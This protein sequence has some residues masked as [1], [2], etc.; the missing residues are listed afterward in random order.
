ML[1]KAFYVGLSSPLRHEFGRTGL[2][3]ELPP[4]ANSPPIYPLAEALGPYGDSW[5]RYVAVFRF[6]S[7]VF[8]NIAAE[9]ANGILENIKRHGASGSFPAGQERSEDFGVDIVRD[10]EEM[11][12]ANGDYATVKELEMNSVAVIS[13]ILAQSVALDSYGDTVDSLMAT[14]ASINSTV[15]RSGNFSNTEKETLF[16]V[17]AQNNSLFIDMVGRLGIKDRSE[18]AWNL[19]EY[20]RVWGD[21]KEGFEIEERFGQIE[22]KLNLI[23]Q[24][25]KFFLGL[26]HHQKSN[27]LEWVIIVLIAF[28]GVLMCLDMS[29]LGTV[30]FKLLFEK[31]HMNFPPSK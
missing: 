11:A 1:S 28:E 20:E 25:A 4:E 15:R 7:V 19:S 14:F 13:K 8:F 29:G 30:G 26:L 22:F 17:V 18:T 9:E 12:H 31:L 10:M 16:K 6:G 23:Q 5:P 2:I 21:M 3:V 27:H 24:N